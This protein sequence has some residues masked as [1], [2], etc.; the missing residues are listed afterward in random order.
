MHVDSSL[1]SGIHTPTKSTMNIPYD[2]LQTYSELALPYRY[3][4]DKIKDVTSDKEEAAYWKKFLQQKQKQLDEEN[5]KKK[6][7]KPKK[8]K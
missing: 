6:K 8:D 1:I 2:T 3:K 7:E 5:A 4:K